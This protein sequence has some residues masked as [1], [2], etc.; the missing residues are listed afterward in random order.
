LIVSASRAAISGR[1]EWA[2]LGACAVALVTLLGVEFLVPPNLPVGS[3]V[4]ALV[5]I[6]AV[7]LDRRRIVPV[8]ALALG[9]RAVAAGLGDISLGL[10][11]LEASSFLIVA[12]VVSGFR[13]RDSLSGA[14]ATDSLFAGIRVPR[15][16]AAQ[17]TARERQVLQM[18]L[19]GLTAAQ[20]AARLFISRRTVE[21]HLERSYS[22]LGVR[23]KRELLASLFDR[24]RDA[25]PHE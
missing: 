18:A 7:F 14:A 15:L 1:R 16:E 9:T 5:V 20:V 17:L 11:A 6:S 13:T 25:V 8:L 19:H 24:G 12:G 10:A 22:K 3:V 2:L 4:L 23:S 21:T